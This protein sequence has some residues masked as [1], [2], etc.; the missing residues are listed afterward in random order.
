MRGLRDLKDK[1]GGTQETHGL[2]DEKTIRLESKKNKERNWKLRGRCTGT[3]FPPF[4]KLM[5]KVSLRVPC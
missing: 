5:T 3:G 4:F 2:K 1:K